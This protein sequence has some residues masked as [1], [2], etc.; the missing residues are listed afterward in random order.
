[1]SNRRGRASLSPPG[2]RGE[3]A[4]VL[5]RIGLAVLV[6]IVAVLLALAVQ[7]P[8]WLVIAF[9][10]ALFVGVVTALSWFAFGG[11]P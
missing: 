9:D 11:R 1:M 8:P 5:R 3:V 4:Y 6:V 2:V 7:L 10:F